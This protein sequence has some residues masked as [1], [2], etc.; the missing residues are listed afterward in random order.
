M[1]FGVSGALASPLVTAREAVDLIRAARR[2]GVDIF[3]T[4]PL[5]GAGEG[6][7]RLGAALADEPDAIVMTRVG[8]TASG[9]RERRRDFSSEAVLASVETSLRRLRRERIDVL[10]LHGAARNDLTPSLLETLQRLTESGKVGHVGAAVRGREIHNIITIQ[11][12]EALMLPINPFLEEQGRSVLTT[13]RDAD[14]V[15]FAIE[16]LAGAVGG[17]ALPT[18]GGLWRLIKRLASRA[19]GQQAPYQQ[20]SGQPSPVSSSGAA[21]PQPAV[22]NAADAFNFA[23]GEGGADAALFT[24]TSRRHLEENV[25]NRTRIRP[26]PAMQGDRAG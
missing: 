2:G 4:A 7:R 1:A 17:G 8:V 13:A 22:L 12:I 16:C 11:M 23:L 18:R 3:D 25:R 21:A 15:I 20:A 26:A 5:Y 24:T 9:L 19:P 10:W 14:R 6:E